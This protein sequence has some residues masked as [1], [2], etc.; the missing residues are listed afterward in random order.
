MRIIPSYKWEIYHDRYNEN[1]L[2]KDYYN[3][4]EKD[5][6]IQRLTSKKLG[7]LIV[8]YKEKHLEFAWKANV[9]EEYRRHAGFIIPILLII[10]IRIKKKTRKQKF[11]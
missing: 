7:G 8:P 9:S 11:I 2:K 4:A 10:Y 6:S 1:I 3:L 5:S